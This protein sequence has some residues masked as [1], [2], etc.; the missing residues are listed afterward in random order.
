[1]KKLAQFA[2]AAALTLLVHVAAPG[3]AQAAATG[4]TRYCLEYN[5]GGTDCSF[6]SLAQCDAT[7][8]GIGAECSID[9]ADLPR[10]T[11]QSHALR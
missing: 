8:D 10:R 9:Y 1:M 6:T 5:E 4:T 7:A 2:A 11:L 3:A